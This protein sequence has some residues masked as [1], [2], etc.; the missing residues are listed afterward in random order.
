[1]DV[2]VGLSILTGW[3]LVALSWMSRRKRKCYVGTVSDILVYPL[4]SGRRLKDVKHATLNKHGLF[5][6]GIGDR[7]WIICRN[8]ERMNMNRIPRI[9]TINTFVEGKNLRLEVNGFEP[10]IIPADPEVSEKDITKIK[11]S[12]VPQ[13]ALDCGDEAATWL[14]KVLERENL[15]LYHSSAKI[16]KRLASDSA[17]EKKWKTEIQPQDEAAFQDFGTCMIMSDSSMEVLN[18]R[19]EKNIHSVQFRPNIMVKGSKPFDEDNWKEVYIGDSAVLRFVDMCQR[20]LM[21][22][23]DYET[24]VLDKEE[25]PLK[26]LKR[27]RCME[28]YGPTKPVMG[29]QTSFENGG[30]IKLGDPVY[31]IRK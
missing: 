31:V 19:I 16:E 8:G 6:D 15:R 20:C 5:V 22:T 1:M 29:I 26:E 24:G 18:Q 4:K 11:F 30:V 17:T 25:Q 23:R 2:L 7:H 10:L 28:A 12:T 3:K 27:F 21:V 9:V 13:L 14:C